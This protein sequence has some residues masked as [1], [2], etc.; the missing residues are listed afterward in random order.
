MLC[1]EGRPVV[2]TAP[3]VQTA[4]DLYAKALRAP[5]SLFDLY[6]NPR[7]Q[8]PPKKPLRSVP[9]AVV[10]SVTAAFEAF[11]E[12]LVVINLVRSG[13]TWAQIAK[14]ANMT[15][16]TLRDLCTT[17]KHSSGVDISA[18]KDEQGDAY[19][20]KLWKQTSDT[21][22]SLSDKMDWDGLLTSSEGWMQVRHCLAHGLTTGTEPAFWPGPVTGKS[23]ANQS[24]VPTASSVLA[25][26]SGSRRALTLYPALNCATVYSHGGAHIAVQVAESLNEKVDY[27]GLTVFDDV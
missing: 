27:S 10:Q 23:H 3:S 5:R 2:S 24:S 18:P 20:W 26:S 15:N 11:A 21:G 16:P 1:E 7:P 25:R 13:A 12:E 22:W 4:V 17:L 19:S 6:P 8:A 9:P 14:N